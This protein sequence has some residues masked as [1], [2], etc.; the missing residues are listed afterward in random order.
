MEQKIQD[1]K[2]NYPVDVASLTVWLFFGEGG[3]YCCC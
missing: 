1:F 2:L 3:S